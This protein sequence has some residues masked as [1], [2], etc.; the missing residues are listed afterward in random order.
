MLKTALIIKDRSG[1]ELFR[2]LQQSPDLALVGLADLSGDSDWLTEQERKEY[3]VTADP[4]RV[5]ALPDLDVLVNATGDQG[6]LE[7]NRPESQR[8]IELVELPPDGFLA[9]VLLSG[10][11]LLE[12]RLLKGE[13]WAVLNSVHDAVEVVDASGF[14]K[15]VNPAFTRV[16]GIPEK[17]RV[18]RNIFQV[19]PH[20]A[21]AQSLV[22]Q[23]PVTGY[24][25]Y[26]GGSGVEVVSSASPIK[27][28]GEITGA[29]VVFQP[30]SDILKL[31]DELKQSNALIENLYDQINRISGAHRHF[32][33]LVGQ[34]RLFRATVEMARKAAR[35]E[36]PVLIRGE[37]GT[38][39]N[40]FAQVI[41]SGGA[42]RE[43]P[44]IV[45][46]CSSVPDSVQEIELFGCEKGAL[47]GVVRTHLGKIELAHRGTLMIKEI[48]SLS[49]FLQ[50]KLLHFIN[51]GEFYRIGGE[52]A[53]EADVRIIATAGEDLPARVPRGSFND[54][55]Y[56]QLAASE[57]VIPALRKRLEDVPLLARSFMEQ[58]NRRLGRQ[59]REIAPRAMQDCMEYD[60]PGNVSEL[61]G[62][63][64][65]AMA[66]ADGTVIEHYH[67]TPYSDRQ[68]RSGGTDFDEIVPLDKME[69][70]MLKLAL[71][72]YGESLE[73]KKKAARALNISLAT[74]YNKLKKYNTL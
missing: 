3:F 56:Q 61:K 23:K 66:A 53:G 10:E 74:L 52:S 32:D 7:R 31:M 34:S 44:L 37:N 11:K 20:G 19:S 73:G 58:L 68:G 69:Q 4:A 18:N 50:D 43:R 54:E 9:K 72:R 63:M 15:Y 45:F 29:V 49:P 14:I 57:I 13:L 64:E 55:L 47:P 27:V 46:D 22:R 24:R 39:K 38:G 25:T 36:S 30:V 6:L 40:V 28:D 59:V 26:V 71:A 51:T 67:M 12:A 62:A 35:G 42:R 17:K 2:F 65:R 21:L 1:V 16:T 8:Q 5:A 60:W 70:V 33:D 41:H 48:C